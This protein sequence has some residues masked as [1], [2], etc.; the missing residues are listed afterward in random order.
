MNNFFIDSHTHLDMKVYD[1]DREEV[2]EN[3]IK[4]SVKYFLNVGYDLESSI[5]SD[6]FSKNYDNIYG[7][8]GFHPHDAKDFKDSYLIDFEK[9]IKENKKILAIGEMGL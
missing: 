9:L 7:S 6:K 5:N 3:S 1:K 8:L 4:S 2:I